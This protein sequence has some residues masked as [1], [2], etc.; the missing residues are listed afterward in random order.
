MS[1]RWQ[2]EPMPRWPYRDTGDGRKPNP[3][4]STFDDTLRLLE[5]ELDHLDVTGAV[6]VRVVARDAD[7]RR[8][9]MLRA[10]A[11]VLH[12]GVAISFRSASH[13]DLTY[14]CDQFYARYYGEVGWQVN[15]RAITL[16]LEALRRLDRY[17]IAGRGEQYAGWR[18]IEA[19][20]AVT[21]ATADEAYRWLRSFTGA[22][23]HTHL[24][25][26]LTAAAA[27]ARRN[28][29][30]GDQSTWDRYRAA[31]ELLEAEGAGS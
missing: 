27:R 17:G 8:D 7:V 18:A 6:A 20:P 19:A 12:P 29:E 4:R 5:E 31:R 9:G 14:P 25:V 21:F 11:D 13:G 16:G 3:F 23:E 22:A 2:I 30:S 1:I 10:R 26:V 15:L 24:S 28:R